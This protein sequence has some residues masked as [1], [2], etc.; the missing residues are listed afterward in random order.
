V[1]TFHNPEAEEFK[2]SVKRLAGHVEATL[3]L[4]G[5]VSA[6]PLLQYDTTQLPSALKT[7]QRSNEAAPA[8]AA[9]PVDAAVFCPSRVS[10]G[11]NFLVQVFLY[12]PRASATVARLARQADEEA[13]RRG[14]YSLPID[15]PSGTR[16]DLHLQMPRLTITNSDAVLIW[17]GKPTAAQFDVDVPVTV[18]DTATTGTVTLAAEGIPLGTL[19][20]K[21]AFAAAGASTEVARQ[22]EVAAVRYRRAFTSYS[23]QDR[24]EVLRRVQP[25]VSPVF[26]SSKDVLDLDPGERWERELYRQIDAC[27]VFLLFWSHAA[28]ASEWVAKEIQ[29]ALDR[30]GGSDEKPPAIQPVPI[31]GPPPVPP[32]EALKHLHFN[33]ALLAHIKSAGIAPYS[34][35]ANK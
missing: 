12:S 28:A 19:S 30:K 15:L 4:A 7:D 27:D 34:T 13:V 29:Y 5:P 11:S 14:K 18:P 2:L 17:R 6:P 21:V 10:K 31:E 3:L 22:C 20:F 26:P 16:V 23:S 24:A 25:S 8:A 33:D 1:R 9:E 32:P 35:T